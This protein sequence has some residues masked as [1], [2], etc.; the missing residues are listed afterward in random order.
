MKKILFSTLFI[1][2][3]F[4]FTLAKDKLPDLE[5]FQKIKIFESTQ[6]DVQKILA[7]Y[8]DEDYDEENY[9]HTISAENGYISIK[10]SEGNCGEDEYWNVAKGLVTGVSISNI[11]EVKIKDLNFDLKHFKKEIEDEDFPEEVNY[12]DEKK[13]ILI[14]TEDGEVNTIVFYPPKN[15]IG[16]L[17]SNENTAEILSGEMKLFE[18]VRVIACILRNLPPVINDINLSQ[19]EIFL[20]DE[21]AETEISVY[22]STTDPENDPLTYNYEVSAGKIVGVGERII[23]DLS[24]VSS[25]TYTITATIDD[26]C[27]DCAAPK[28]E[29]VVIKE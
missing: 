29:T 13:G 20:N 24:G 26:G 23:W 25:G 19:S 21:N 8:L 15:K 4:N 28:T 27:G 11:S 10:F 2:L 1:L 9:S 7:K 14:E 12:H 6:K 16:F 5:K 17:C 22:V 18:T 3:A